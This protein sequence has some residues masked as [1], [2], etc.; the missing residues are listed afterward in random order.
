MKFVDFNSFFERQIKVF[1]YVG[2]RFDLSE[3][4]KDS[5]STKWINIVYCTIC[6]I[7]YGAHVLLCF[8]YFVLSE[9]LEKK[10]SVFPNLYAHIAAFT[11]FLTISKN[12][13]KLENS[14]KILREQFGHQELSK[15]VE[16]EKFLW[17]A[18]FICNLN[19]FFNYVSPI[20]FILPL[21]TTFSNYWM[22]GRFDPQYPT[23]VW[24][25]FEAVEYY[26]PFYMFV[27][28]TE[29]I[30]V[31]NSGAANCLLYMILIHIT[32]QFKEIKKTM[33]ELKEHES[34][35]VKLINRQIVLFE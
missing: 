20:I 28:Y 4:R 14:L 22:Q 23:D 32:Q 1:K 35:I 13:K 5:A 9:E 27:Y 3:P 21:I 33:S 24:T 7:L 18:S 34:K 10:L 15:L 26:L 8:L 2:I 31:L 12:L 6:Y 11:N 29:V 30:M 16:K 25:P 19:S 17:Q